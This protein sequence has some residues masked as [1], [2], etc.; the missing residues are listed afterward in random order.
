MDMIENAQKKNLRQPYEFDLDTKKT[1]RKQEKKKHYRI[2][3]KE[4]FVVFNQNCLKRYHII[5]DI[6]S[7][8]IS[9][10]ITYHNISYQIISYHIVYHIS[11]V[12]KIIADFTFRSVIK[13]TFI[14]KNNTYEH[15]N[16]H[17]HIFSHTHIDICTHIRTHPHTHPTHTHTYMYTGWLKSDY[18]QF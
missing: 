12:W 11:T 15:T 3:K 6:I 16:S 14:E 7:Y 2:L 5:Y 8:F 1:G 9:Y 17:T 13:S 10:F 4:N 18:T